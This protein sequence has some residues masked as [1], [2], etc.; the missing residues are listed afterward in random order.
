LFTKSLDYKSRIEFA[1]GTLL[2]DIGKIKIPKEIW[3]KRAQLTNSQQQLIKNH[4][5]YG[6]KLVGDQFS[7]YVKDLIL[8]HHERLDGSG[9]PNQLIENEIDFSVRLLSIID[10]YSSLTL[11]RV[12][13]E[14]LSATKALECM[15]CEPNKFDQTLLGKFMEFLHIFPIGSFVALTNNKLVKVIGSQHNAIFIPEVTEIM[16]KST[17][18]LP[19]NL[20]LSVKRYISWD[21]EDNALNKWNLFIDYLLSRK[22]NLAFKIFEELSFELTFDNVYYN[23][24]NPA[25]KEFE[26]RGIKTDIIEQLLIKWMHKKFRQP[27]YV[28]IT[29]HTEEGLFQY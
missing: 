8:N 24:V 5:N 15:L 20:S 12:D 25:M 23:I 16:S 6:R 10:V 3:E 17:F 2:Y 7:N 14:P 13:R 22:K 18:Y 21:Q 28:N 1:K 29:A 11:R 27:S 4:T 19:L 26:Q 9:Y